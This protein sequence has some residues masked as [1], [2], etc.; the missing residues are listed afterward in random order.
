LRPGNPEGAGAR[1]GADGDLRLRPAAERVILEDDSPVTTALDQLLMT[2]VTPGMK[3][4]WLV[5]FQMVVA[6]L[7]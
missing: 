6:R 3:P 1:I 4:R 5:R 2:L 7:G